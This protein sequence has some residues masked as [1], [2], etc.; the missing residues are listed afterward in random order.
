M[1]EA[2]REGDKL[3]QNT[4]LLIRPRDHGDDRKNN[5]RNC[6]FARITG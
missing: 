1:L 2:K 5:K 6:K 4:S 3:M